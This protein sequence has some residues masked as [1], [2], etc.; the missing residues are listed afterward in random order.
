MLKFF[1]DDEIAEIEYKRKKEYIK[2]VSERKIEI[3]G[4]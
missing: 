2:Q 1:V 4:R 3:N